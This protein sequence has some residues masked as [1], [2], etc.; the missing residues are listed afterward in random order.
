MSTFFQQ[1][2]ATGIKRVSLEL[3]YI[4]DELSVIVRP[5]SDSKDKALESM[6]P[7]V[8]KG[9]PSEMD[10]HFFD[11]VLKPLEITSEFMTNLVEY[12]K[13]LEETKKNSE[14]NEK[15]KDDA[16]K[17]KK[18]KT[19][20]LEKAFRQLEAITGTEG[21]D[22]KKEKDKVLKALDNIFAIDPNNKKAQDFKTDFIK[23]TTEV[24]LFDIDE[25]EELNTN[26]E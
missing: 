25:M 4:N 12:E 10:L 11:N 14:M 9:T 18:E 22:A 21:Y 24:S 2:A 5:K 6:R 26:K 16:K 3:I 1:M 23:Q 13:S 15:V 8:L 17:Q 7:I 20:K 19:E